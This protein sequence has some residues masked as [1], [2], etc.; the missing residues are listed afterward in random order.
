LENKK[1]IEGIKWS[2]LNENDKL[3]TREGE[4]MNGENEKEHERYREGERLLC[5]LSQ[6]FDP[7]FYL[8][9]RHAQSLLSTI[10]PYLF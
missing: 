9:H 8:V 2:K 4:E 1:Q 3:T 7:L 6:F 10:A 5:H